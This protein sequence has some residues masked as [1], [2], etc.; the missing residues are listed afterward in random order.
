M[1]AHRFVSKI[2]NALQ[3]SKQLVGL[4]AASAGRPVKKLEHG[5]FEVDNWA[6]S[7][8]IVDKLVPVVGVHPFPLSEQQLLAAATCW[9]RPTHIFEWGTHIGKSA[10][11]FYETCQMF[12]IPADIN[13]IDLPNKSDH[14]EHPGEQRGMLVRELSSVHLH[15]GDGLETAMKIAQ[16]LTPDARLLFFLDGDH[17]YESVKR[18]LS[19][20]VQAYPRAAILLHDTF[21]Q[22]P[23]SGYN[24]GPFQALHE[25]LGTV[26]GK[27][28]EVAM[29]TGLPGMTFI[30]PTP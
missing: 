25:I 29:S 22:K 17:S 14:N 4:S 15:L 28:C 24:V 6:I 27:Y 13:S 9:F 20:I 2:G 3:Q 18:E 26:P 19:S 10:R 1:N 8:F 7:K 11:I 30:Y 16:Q 12:D 23:E 21:F 5:F